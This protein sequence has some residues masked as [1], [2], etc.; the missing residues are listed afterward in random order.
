MS[1]SKWVAL[2]LVASLAS[3]IV[4]Y[5]LTNTDVV[6]SPSAASAPIS[7][8]RTGS[9]HEN[10]FSFNAHPKPR[11]LPELSFVDSEGRLANLEAF[12][13]RVVLLN[14]WAT[15]CGPC[16]EEMPALDRLQARLGG[17]QF[18][19]VALSID[20]EG[21]AVVKAFYEELGLESLAIYIDATNRAATDLGILGIP[22]TLLIDRDGKEI[23]RVLGPAEWDSPQVV[24][25][26]QRYLPD[27]EHRG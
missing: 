4:A 3:G 23:G 5:R 25:A 16:R 10:G 1:S 22:G 2:L 14:V 17:S 8:P 15:W 18:Q 7:P 6:E 11:E 27:H 21:L 9:A 20:R 13:G 26:I 12:R 19:V 24:D